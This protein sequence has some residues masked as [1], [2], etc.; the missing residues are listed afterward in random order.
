MIKEEQVKAETERNKLEQTFKILEVTLKTH[1]D[2][3]KTISEN[4][5]CKEKEKEVSTSNHIL[6]CLMM[7]LYK[8]D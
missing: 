4:L 1:Q 7:C 3:I 8:S 6:Q 5:R 2:N